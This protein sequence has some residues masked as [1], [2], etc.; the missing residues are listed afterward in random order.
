MTRAGWRCSLIGLVLTTCLVVPV[1]PVWPAGGVPATRVSRINEEA[2]QAQGPVWGSPDAASPTLTYE[3]N[4]RDRRIL[5]RVAQQQGDAW[6]V[7]DVPLVAAGAPGSFLLSD[8]WTD[9][10]VTWAGDD[11]FFFSRTLDSEPA[12]YY[13]DVAP[14]RVPWEMGAVEHPAVST[15]GQQLAVAITNKTGTDLHVA[16]VGNWSG[17]NQLTNSPTVV[18][19]SP[20]WCPSGKVMVYAATDRTRTDLRMLDPTSE[21]PKP[22]VLYAKDD[23][24]LAPACCTHPA[25]LLFAVYIRATDGSHR[26][27]V[28]DLMGNIYRQ[29]NGVYLEPGRA[30]APAWTPGGRY[31]VYVKADPSKGNPIQ[32]LHVGSGEV[33]TIPVNTSGNLEVGVGKWNGPQGARTML[34]VIAVG[35]TAGQNVRNH[36]YAA[37]ITDSVPE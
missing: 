30:P 18:E 9:R 22:H 29:V 3:V 10:G 32:A 34:A 31:I 15:D 25:L 17:A 12:L 14:H 7:S 2:M 23:E 26:L 27:L 20:S 8:Q 24:V 36:L 13:Y 21:S 28:V 33:T 16:Q 19:H 1:K 4:D 11:G 37:D 35:D 5:L 6:D